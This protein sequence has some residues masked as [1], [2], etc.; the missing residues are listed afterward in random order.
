MRATMRD[1]PWHIS[2]GVFAMVQAL[3]WSLR[4]QQSGQRIEERI[5]QL[6][7]IAHD[8]ELGVQLSHWAPR[9]LQSERL[10]PSGNAAAPRQQAKRESPRAA[11]VWNDQERSVAGRAFQKRGTPR[12]AA[13]ICREV[14]RPQELI[15]PG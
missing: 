8:V 1:I 7:G 9:V 6:T 11:S 3:L 4:E 5:G 2:A 10:R 13:P 14:P 12:N 15:R